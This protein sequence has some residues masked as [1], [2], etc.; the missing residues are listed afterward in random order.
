MRPADFRRLA[1]NMPHA[2]ESAH[3]GHPDFRVRNRIFATLYRLERNLA[4]VKLT[5]EQ[6]R[7]LIRAHPEAFAPIA[8]GWGRQGATEVRL[9]AATRAVL[10]GALMTAWRNAAPP[11]LA[12]GSIMVDRPVFFESPREFRGWLK[13]HHARA[14]E[15]LVGFHKRHTG[16]PTMTWPES[17]A[18]ALCFGWIDGVR[19]RLDDSRYTIRFTPRRK[20]AWSAI[21]VRMV[22][23]LESDGHMTNA[24][25]AAFEAR[26]H[27]TGPKAK[28]YSYERRAAEFDAARLQAFKRQRAAWTFFQ[29]QP[30]G[31]RKT[32]A[33][34]VMNAK[35]ER[36]MDTR[37]ARLIK[38]SA[39]RTRL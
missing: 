2:V 9:A 12:N 19:K 25:R 15:L 30:P 18:E 5:P 14:R 11:S 28:G 21:N 26:P 37:L 17:V 24:G 38:A 6:Q 35:R 33:W 4:M 29:A 7:R 32:A 1:L 3:M 13:K 8:G 23:Q 10:H 16:Q 36:T 20:G 31:Y 22:A 34:W 39:A 27:K